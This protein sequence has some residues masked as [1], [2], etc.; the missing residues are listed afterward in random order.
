MNNSSTAFCNIHTYNKNES[1]FYQFLKHL[2]MLFYLILL[3]SSLFWI[4]NLSNGFMKLVI[5]AGFVHIGTSG[6][7]EWQSRK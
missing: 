2:G 6:G 4:Y 5:K 3:C 1:N 7:S